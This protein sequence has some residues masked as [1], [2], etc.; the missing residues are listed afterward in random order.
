MGKRRAAGLQGSERCLSSR[1]ALEGIL[2]NYLLV[3][4]WVVWRREIVNG[5]KS[6]FSAGSTK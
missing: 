5:D 1:F 6:G 2:G 4:I 3:C